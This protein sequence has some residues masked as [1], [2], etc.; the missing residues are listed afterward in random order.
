MRMADSEVLVLNVNDDAATR[1]LM[2]R[3]LRH[4]GYRVEEAVN[5]EDALRLVFEQR[6][7][8]VLLDIKLPDLSGLEVCRRIK[9]DPRSGK[10]CVLQTSATFASGDRKAEGLDS[11]ADAYLAQPLE[12]VEL[13]ATIRAL[14]R[15]R[16]AEEAE[17]RAARRLERTFDAIQ[18]A[19]LLV[20]KTGSVEQCNPAASRLFGKSVDELARANLGDLL[21]A[22]FKPELLTPLLQ[23][24]SLERREIEGQ[25]EGRYYRLSADPVNGED[26]PVDGAV[27][28]LSDISDRKRLE[29]AHRLRAEELAEADRRKDEFLGMLAHEL[30]NPLNAIS[31]ANTILSCNARSDSDQMR[32]YTIISR[33][34][35]NLARLVDDLLEVSR[36]TR[37]KLQ[38][39][40][41]PLDFAALVQRVTQASQSVVDARKQTL[42]VSLPEKPL[43]MDGDDLRLEQVLSNLI[44][45]AS[46]YSPPH[47]LI[48][49]ELSESGSEGHSIAKLEV[50]DHGIGIPS[51]MLSKVFEPFVQGDQS[52]S[53]TLGGLGIGLT[54]VKNLVELHGGW[55]RA[56]SAGSGLGAK[57]IIGLPLGAEINAAA[58]EPVTLNTIRAKSPA[59]NVLVIEDNPDTLEL[60]QT[61]L[62]MLGYS[63][64]GANNGRTG[65][66]LAL[67]SMP[68]VA[69][70]DIGL[71]I[72]DGYEV[73]KTLR[74]LEA[75]KH[76][77]LVAVTGYG[78]PEDRARALDAGFDAHLVKPI[79]EA[80]LLR[81]LKPAFSRKPAARVDS[82]TQQGR[83]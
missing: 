49:V 74:S 20:S 34:T 52:L 28:I 60:L 83:A 7:D 69:L 6:P 26:R 58:K 64:R 3:I 78:R 61:L 14:L 63:V 25:R 46:K 4:G 54:M 79:D 57:F 12:P 10:T 51:D 11:G 59:L 70:V 9:A 39:R 21:S 5:G 66:E 2:S 68:D 23:S 27:L 41:Q 35:R 81:V 38:L 24:S 18:D 53:R 17:R 73:A 62:G 65:M 44:S 1:Y 43:P 77:Y 48:E 82:S 19:V 80:G 30:R 76:L 13:L 75:G 42:R 36:I 56:E 37:G 32:L 45:N 15:T 33:Q 29:E 50:T 67:S 47:S 22:Y 55:V 8:V 16:R 71:P 72:I 31:A 40:R